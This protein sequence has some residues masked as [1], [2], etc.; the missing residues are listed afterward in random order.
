[1]PR[2]LAPLF[3]T[4]CLLLL[5]TCLS[6][7]W[8]AN[9]QCEDHQE[10]N[11]ET[12]ECECV[13]ALCPGGDTCGPQGKE[14]RS[15]CYSD[16]DCKEGYACPYFDCEP[17]CVDSECPNGFRCDPSDPAFCADFCVDN[18]ECRAGFVCCTDSDDCADPF[19]QCIPAG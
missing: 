13:D 10:C 12:A 17:L 15:D 8:C 6:D 19:D 2:A 9:K 5:P 18:A 14:C 7:D 16:G 4:L 3:W 11:P 1:M